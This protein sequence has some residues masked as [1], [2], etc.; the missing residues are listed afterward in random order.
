MT[1][2]LD[3]STALYPPTVTPPPQPL[4]LRRFIFRVIRN[5]LE[6]LPQ[7]AYEEPIVA[8]GRSGPARYCWVLAPELVEEVLVKRAGAFLKSPLEKRVFHRTLRDGVLSSD[9]ALWRW[10]RR[11]M[12]PLFRHAEIVAYIPDM[13]QPAEDQLAKWRATPP[14]SIQQID[15]DMV[16]TTFSVIARTM[17]TGGAPAEAQIIKTA[18]A[19]SLTHIS[20]DL[21]YGVLSMPLWAPHPASWLLSRSAKR[22]RAAVERIIARRQAE[23]G[24]GDD[25]LDRLLAARDPESGAPMS[26]EQLV[27]NLLTL[28]E[29]GHETTSRALTWTLYLLARSPQWQDR[30]RQEVRDAAGKGPISAE[31]LDALQVTQQVLKEAMRLYAPV[32]VMSRIATEETEIGGQRIAAGGMVIIPIFC[33]H[34]HIRLWDDPGRFDPTRFSPEREA[35]YPRTQF[36]PFGGGARICLGS[37]FAMTEATVILASLV[38]GARFVWDGVHKPEPVSRVTLQPRGGMPLKVTMLEQPPVRYA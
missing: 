14:G 10:Q 4:P 11:S 27:N 16:E 30:V 7:A 29:A 1:D 26:M 5:P 28:L 36:M 33:I 18:T 25:L 8:L 17:L 31:H 3:V 35:A 32:P 20:W 19:Q 15:G 12:A 23:G 22:L 37:A 13:A 2:A 21:L 34:R 6:V 24:A 9:G 38:R